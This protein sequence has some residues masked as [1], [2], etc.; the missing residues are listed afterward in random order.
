MSILFT[1]L[2]VIMLLNGGIDVLS[3]QPHAQ[4]FLVLS[5]VLASLIFGFLA[6]WSVARWRFDGLSKRRWRSSLTYVATNWLAALSTGV[7]VFAVLALSVFDSVQ[8]VRLIVMV[9]AI[10]FVVVCGIGSLINARSRGQLRDRSAFLRGF[11][12][13]ALLNTVSMGVGVAAGRLYLNLF[14][15]G[16]G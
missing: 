4:Q 14:Y 9:V 13:Y 12:T 15:P 5:C 6:E 10:E 16:V 3:E 1:I 2:V 8:F 7:F 11:G